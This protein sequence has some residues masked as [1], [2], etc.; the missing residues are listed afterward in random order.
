MS[1]NLKITTK[2]LVVV[3]GEVEKSKE[4]SSVG[5]KY[6]CLNSKTQ[7]LEAATKEQ[8]LKGG[9][10]LL[11]LSSISKIA[12]NAFQAA[13]KDKTSIQDKEIAQI[14]NFVKNLTNNEE[15]SELHGLKWEILD[16]L[17]L[18]NIKQKD[19][20]QTFKEIEADSQMISSNVV[21]KKLEQYQKALK[22]M[23]DFLNE[24]VK[25]DPKDSLTTLVT[26][27]PDNLEKHHYEQDDRFSGDIVRTVQFS[28][29]DSTTT[30]SSAPFVSPFNKDKDELTPEEEIANSKAEADHVE[31]AKDKVKIAVKGDP[32][33]EIPL[34]CALT[35]TVGNAL[36]GEVIGKALGKGLET[37]SDHPAFRFSLQQHN[38]A[39]PPI[40]FTVNRYTDGEKRGKIESIDF[41]SSG[42]LDLIC[43][44]GNSKSVV[45]PHCITGT[46]KFKMKLGQVQIHK[47]DKDG[48]TIL[49]PTDKYGRKI[50]VVKG[51]AYY[52]NGKPVPL[53]KQL[54]E[55]V[56]I[57]GP[58]ITEVTRS[59]EYNSSL[60]M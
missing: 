45:S 1:D 12:E 36:F 53:D 35:Q 58:V 2:E 17:S 20:E 51:M 48:Q 39:F 50:E 60:R 21:V 19:A 47:L 55:M 22:D 23:N 30:V 44:V 10:T 59:L 37:F 33:W 3:L 52:P 43:N 9:L 38:N 31:Q 42:S 27:F 49:K 13:L 24:L 34:Q 14:I 29:T 41:E 4:G 8:I 25:M 28:G 46:I 18:K 54:H 32:E 56:T 7:K 40:R 16:I 26:G 15:L 57:R 11:T 5:R 6:V